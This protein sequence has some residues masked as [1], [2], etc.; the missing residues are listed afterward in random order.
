[1]N[2]IFKVK[3]DIVLVLLIKGDGFMTNKEVIFNSLSFG[4]LILAKRLPDTHEIEKGHRNGPFLVIGRKDERLICLYATSKENKTTLIKVSKNNYNLNKETYITSSIRLISIDEFL[5]SIYYLNEKEKKDLIKFL[6]INGLENNSF[7]EEPKLEKGDVIQLKKQH[8]IVGETSDNYVT[9][10]IEYNDS[11]EI[12]E[13]D[14]RHKNF[15]SKNSKYKR[16][17]FLSE[18]ELNKHIIESRKNYNQK[19]YGKLDKKIPEKIISPLNVGN[20]VIYKNLLYYLYFELGNKKLAFSVS[21]NQT[22]ISKKITIGGAEYY[23]NFGIKR[24]FDENQENVLLVATATEEEK[25]LIKNRKN[26]NL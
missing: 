21:K 8:L 17:A 20:L 4:D 14:Y 26:N 12:L 18:E 15:V 13:V 24:D 23:A 2:L 1:M 7:L 11:N 19:K 3:C 6:Y 5:S 10:K 25:K 16:V 22:P 9:I